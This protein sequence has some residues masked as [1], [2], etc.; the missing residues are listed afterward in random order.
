MSCCAKDDEVLPLAYLNSHFQTGLKNVLDRAVLAH[1]ETHAQANIDAFT[2]STRSRSTS[3]GAS[4]RSW[5]ARPKARTASSPRALRSRCSPVAPSAEL[6]GEPLPMDTGHIADLQGGIRAAE[7]GR[8]PRA[9]D[10][11]AGLRGAHGCGRRHAYGKADEQDLVLRGYVAFLDPPKD[12]AAAAIEALQRARRFDQGPDW[13]QRAGRPQD[14][15]GGRAGDRQRR[16][17]RRD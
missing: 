13:R 3:S 14:L 1:T 4:C 8:L 11:D 12:G 10:R 2:K 6:D 17:R 16:P 5:C 15:P 7:R 9:G